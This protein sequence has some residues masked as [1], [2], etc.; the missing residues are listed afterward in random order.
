MKSPIKRFRQK[1]IIIQECHNFFLIGQINLSFYSAYCLWRRRE[2][3]ST[4]RKRM[5]D[6]KFGCCLDAGS[7]VS[8][9]RFLLHFLRIVLMIHR[10]KN[11]HTNAQMCA[12]VIL[13]IQQ[14]EKLYILSMCFVAISTDDLYLLNATLSALANQ[15]STSK[16]QKMRQRVQ[17]GHANRMTSESSAIER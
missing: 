14:L 9:Y 8:M 7:F 10:S 6:H 5:S 3:N 12:T 2:E 16:D 1:D 17:I 11:K 4:A 15:S 13:V